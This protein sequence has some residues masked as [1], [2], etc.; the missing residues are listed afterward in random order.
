M[1]SQ[2]ASSEGRSR[3]PV[4]APATRTQTH[5]KMHKKKKKTLSVKHARGI[6]HVYA[7]DI[8]IA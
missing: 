8:L 2:N 6:E 3:C 5:K 7:E 1:T 4:K